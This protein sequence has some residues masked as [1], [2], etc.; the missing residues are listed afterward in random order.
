M[1]PRIWSTTIACALCA[2]LLACQAQE[3]TDA[4][5]YGAVNHTDVEI[6]SIAINGAGGVLNIG[7]HG[8][9][10]AGVCCVVVPRQWTPGL[11]A[12]I[13]WQEDG[14]WQRDSNGKFVLDAGGDKQFI[15]GPWKTRTVPIPR[16]DGD[17]DFYVFFF[18]GDDVRVAMT[19]SPEWKEWEKDTPEDKAYQDKLYGKR[20]Q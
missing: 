1:T 3:T 2:L 10:N 12:T 19:S 15:E 16:Y 11:T 14:H 7:K 18:P 20:S 6:V 8:S 17:G 5:S 4:V 9:G 13:Q